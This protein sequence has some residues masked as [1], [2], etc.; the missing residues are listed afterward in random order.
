MLYWISRL[1]SPLCHSL[2][3]LAVTDD[4]T[5]V[6]R[7]IPKP[8]LVTIAVAE[9]GGTSS[10]VDTED[11]AMT[12]H[13]LAPGAFRWRKFSNQINLELVRVALVDASRVRGGGYVEGSGKHGWVLT[14]AGIRWMN[15]LG[16]RLRSELLGE[17]PQPTVNKPEPRPQANQR[18]RI[19][20]SDAFASWSAG[21]EVSSA[22]AASVF[23]A[24]QYTPERTRMLKIRNLQA[25]FRD[26]PQIEE[27]LAAMGEIAATN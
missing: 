25:M 17:G 26:D 12:A 14:D 7:T 1:P 2:P 11:I 15:R 23:R 8:E 5:C 4:N 22:Q 19:L 3:Q 16:D 18:S 10:P 27:F 24:D 9:L 13:R 21:V 20:K 6:T